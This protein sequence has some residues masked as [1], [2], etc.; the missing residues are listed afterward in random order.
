MQT[1]QKPQP[2]QRVVIKIFLPQPAKASFAIISN[3]KAHILIY[4]M[5][6]CK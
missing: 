1:P 6:Y 4:A 2:H 5:S 3:L